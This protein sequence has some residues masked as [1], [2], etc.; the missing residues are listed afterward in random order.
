MKPNLSLSFPYLS[1]P[2]GERIGRRKSKSNKE[3]DD[4]LS[5]LS[6]F[7][8][9]PLARTPARVHER[10]RERV[11]ER[12][13]EFHLATYLLVSPVDAAIYSFPR[14]LFFHPPPMRRTVP[15]WRL[16]AETAAGTVARFGTV[17]FRCPVFLAPGASWPR[18]RTERRIRRE[19]ATWRNLV[20]RGRDPW[21][22]NAC[23]TADRNER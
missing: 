7:H 5:I 3:K 14:F 17:C 21:A 10:V 9:H 22:S 2:G 13:K 18:G 1:P 19:N 15:S 20:R 8:P 12:M 6:P 11:G 4:S 23:L 16:C